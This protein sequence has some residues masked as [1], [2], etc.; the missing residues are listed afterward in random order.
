[1]LRRIT[2]IVAALGVA[3]SAVTLARAG[4]APTRAPG[5]CAA[6]SAGARP[7]HRVLSGPDRPRSA[8]RQGPGPARRPLPPARARDRRQPG[9]RACRG[10][11]RAGRSPTGAHG[12]A[13]RWPSSS[14]AL[15]AEHRYAEALASARELAALRAGRALRPGVCWREIE[16]ELGLY[17]RGPSHVRAAR[18][19]DPRSRRRASDRALARARGQDRGG[20]RRPARRR[21]TTP[22][23][24]T[25]CRRSRRRGSTSAS[26][27]WRSATGASA[28]P[29]ARFAAG[30][31]GASRRLPRAGSL[32]PAR[33]GAP[34]LAR[35][36]RVGRAGDRHD[37]GPRHAR[38]GGRRVRGARR[39]R[40]GGGVLPRARSRGRAGRSVRSTEPGV[41]SCSITTGGWTKCCDKAREEIAARQ[42]IYGW[43]LLAWALHQNGRDGEAAP[44]MARA[45]ALGTR[46]AMLFY[47]AGMIERALGDRDAARR[48]SH[49]GA[50]GESLLASHP[51]G[52][53][54]SRA[55]SICERPRDLH[56][57][58]LPAHHR[59]RGA[60]PHPVPAGAGG[61]VPAGRLARR[62]LGRDRVHGRPLDHAGAGGHGRARAAD[63][64]HRV[65]HPGHDRRDGTGE[66]RRAPPGSRGALARALPRRLCGRVRAGPRRGVRQLP[67]EPVHRL[68]R[69]P[70]VRLQRRHRAG[71]AG[72]ADRSRASCS[73]GSTGC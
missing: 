34:R 68:D 12:T 62:A 15:L 37:P 1:M 2:V 69:D 25:R 51:A 54:P 48:T 56:R 28:R 52:F 41:C 14:T 8:G 73:P 66:H 57:A 39:H 10:E 27:I 65:S 36:D 16:M 59:S 6:G 58:R 71:A 18:E 5:A 7:R 26:R 23:S 21:G 45:L 3:A 30:L 55:G 33:G 35:R 70:V 17:R 38:C 32:R 4:R 42:D 11:P 50:G 64:G 19:L 63:G 22:S 24:C 20:P 46:D 53:G 49:R 47:H 31:A 67:P 9:P 29:S 61:R 72:R 13:R 40:E 44:A 60:R 43:D